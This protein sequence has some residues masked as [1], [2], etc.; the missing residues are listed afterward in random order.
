MA[1][2]TA[3]TSLR[4]ILVYEC[5][6]NVVY[7]DGVQLFNA[8]GQRISKTVGGT[9]YNY[10][11]LGD[12]L[13]EMAWGANRMHFTY[14][15]VGPMSVNF[16]GTEYF[17]LKNAQGD[18]TGLVDS[19]GAKVVA[20]TYGP[21]GE[22]WGV[23]G[24]LAS[25]LGDLNPLRYRGYAYDTETGLYYVSIRY[26]DPEIGRWINADDAIAGVGG[27]IRGYN[28]FAYCMNNPVNMRDGCGCM[29]E[30]VMPNNMLA[31]AGCWS[32][33]SLFGII[34]V[35][36]AA[37]ATVAITKIASSDAEIDAKPNTD[38]RT[39]PKPPKGDEEE[40]AVYTVYGLID[41]ERTVQYVG[42]TKNIE[43]RKKA[44]A[45]SNARGHLTMHIFRKNLT[46]DQ[47]RGLEQLLMVHYHTLNALNPANNQ[48]N[49]IRANNP[50]YRH[51]IDSANAL[52][53]NII[54]NEV[55]NILGY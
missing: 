8:S 2:K 44:H 28:L 32:L 38:S 31:G 6:A 11:Y 47:A 49:G 39:K 45:N 16:N 12:Q 22:A 1:A 23:S 42:R 24:T 50:K 41:L 7:F 10:H 37:C 55:L 13:V 21:W 18:V 33:S 53:E 29:A 14:D 54:S 15:A 4:I 5:N 25:T 9:T 20:Y 30:L 17:Y 27:D 46:Y 3:Y 40:P 19:T 43:A 52:F 48:I 36:T 34:G 26:Y 51:Y 35:G